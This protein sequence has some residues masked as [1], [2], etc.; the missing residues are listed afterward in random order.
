MIWKPWVTLPVGPSSLWGLCVPPHQRQLNMLSAS[1]VSPLSWCYGV[2]HP[3]PGTWQSGIAS[4]QCCNIGGL[5]LG[6]SHTFLPCQSQGPIVDSFWPHC[7]SNA[8]NTTGITRLPLNSADKRHPL[9]SAE[10]LLIGTL[11]EPIKLCR[12]T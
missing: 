3:R 4:L 2:G 7:K 10:L 1:W 8:T 11:K 5:T 12:D 6:F 9:P